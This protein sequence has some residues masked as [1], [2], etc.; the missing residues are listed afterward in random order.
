[1]AVGNE[2]AIQKQLRHFL[3]CRLRLIT[4]TVPSKVRNLRKMRNFR[5]KF[6]IFL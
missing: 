3:D 1:M 6:S 4:G 2:Y 5:Q